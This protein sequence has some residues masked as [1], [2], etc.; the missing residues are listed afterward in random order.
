MKKIKSRLS[1]FFLILFLPMVAFGIVVTPIVDSNTTS[2]TNTTVQ[3]DSNTTSETNTTVQSDSN[4]TS[5]TNTTVQSD[6]NTTSETNTTVQSDSNTTSETNT[7]APRIAE[8]LNNSDSNISK[9]ILE[10]LRVNLASLGKVRVSLDSLKNLSDGNLTIAYTVL[11]QKI[12]DRVDY[13]DAIDS[14]ISDLNISDDNRSILTNRVAL[15]K[16]SIKSIKTLATTYQTSGDNSSEA[17][18]KLHG[19]INTI[20]SFLEREG[21]YKEPSK[22]VVILNDSNGTAILENIKTNLDKLGDIRDYID[23]LQNLSDD[24]LTIAYEG[25]IQKIQDRI[26]YIDAL[27]SNISDLNVSDEQK[28]IIRDRASLVR[29]SLE[30]LKTVATDYQTDGDNSSEAIKSLNGNIDVI[31]S[32]LSREGV[33]IPKV[34]I[35]VSKGRSLISGNIDVTK[36]PSEI[37]AV[38]IVDGGNWYG[39]SPDTSVREA[40]KEKY[41]LIDKIIPAYKAVIVWANEDTSIELEDDKSIDNVTQSYGKNFTIHGANN[42]TFSVDDVSCSDTNNSITGLFKVSGD[43]PSVFVPNREIN[44]TENFTYIY[45]DEGYYV[46]CEEKQGGS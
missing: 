39:Y 29:D 42:Q 21:L 5:E 16:E 36:L 22:V 20:L 18:G 41:R 9:D 3:S 7:T 37:Y 34:T 26:D 13:I 30:N 14:N 44:S 6:S 27:D 8:I 25:F 28:S 24:N 15:L 32:I 38:W 46:L 12:Q 31:L 4:T 11:I 19:E 33:D 40:I 17:I 35:E 10:E 45:S 23:N 1:L 43:V 2:E